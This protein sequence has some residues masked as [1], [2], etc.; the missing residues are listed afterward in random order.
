MILWGLGRHS[1][2]KVHFYLALATASSMLLHICLHWSWVC[3]TCCNLPGLKA[4]WVER[5]K[6]MGLCS[7]CY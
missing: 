1:Y 5:Q 7:Y 4:A 3:A 6:I 2:G